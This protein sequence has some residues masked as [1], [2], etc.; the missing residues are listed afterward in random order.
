MVKT[1]VYRASALMHCCIM[2]FYFRYKSSK[3]DDRYI[4]ERI[5]LL[6]GRPL[7]DETK[8]FADN[9]SPLLGTIEN[10]PVL[11]EMQETSNLIQELKD[12]CGMDM[13][14]LNEPKFVL[15]INYTNV[16][17]ECRILSIGIIG[18]CDDFTLTSCQGITMITLC[19]PCF[20]KMENGGHMRRCGKKIFVCMWFSQITIAIGGTV[21]TEKKF[22]WKSLRR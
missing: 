14:E 20:L 10:L 4:Y 11:S 12:N 17:S 16:E 8:E 21:V 15:Y 9:Y 2:G 5:H 19:R 6:R 3:K 18:Y 13:S 1:D 7:L 22:P